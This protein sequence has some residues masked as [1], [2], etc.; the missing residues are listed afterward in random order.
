MRLPSIKTLSAV[1]NDAK[2]AR[3]IL[4]MSRAQLLALPAGEARARGCYNPPKTYDLRMH[5]LTAIDEGLHGLESMESTGGEYAQFLNTGDTYAPTLI[6]WR[7]AYRVQS[8][9]DF[10]ETQERAGV[11]FA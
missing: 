2:Q 7:G 1:F 9:G 4:E 8:V 3:A 6:Y 10:V 11:H 5:C